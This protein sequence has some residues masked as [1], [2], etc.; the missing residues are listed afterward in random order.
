MDD[1]RVL[2]RNFMA[3]YHQQEEFVAYF[4]SNW[5]GD[6]DLL[7]R[8]SKAVLPPQHLGM[9][10]N[11]YTES[12]HNQLKNKY[13]GGVRNRRLDK[14]IFILSTDVETFFSVERDRINSNNGRMG[15]LQ[16]A[17][18]DRSWSA[19]SVP[20]SFLPSMFTNPLGTNASGPPELMDLGG[21][22]RVVSFT[23]ADVY[24]VMVADDRII[25]C[26]CMDFYTRKH[27]C[28]HM[29]LLK[30][31]TNVLLLGTAQDDQGKGLTAR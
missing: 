11:N 21:Q 16:N 17:Q 1:T 27:P 8:W 29:H 3:T 9:F 12:W 4:E 19:M 14:L 2:I 26:T 13:L 7:F 23:N 10:T 5:V 18:A 6:D 15:P 28:K 24:R 20:E 25:S 30:R 22:Y 31:Y